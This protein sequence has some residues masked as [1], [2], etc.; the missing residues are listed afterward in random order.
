M[1]PTSKLV[2]NIQIAGFSI[3]CGAWFIMTTKGI[4]TCIKNYKY[5][6]TNNKK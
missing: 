5:T 2:T 3:S 4:Y 6:A 1:H